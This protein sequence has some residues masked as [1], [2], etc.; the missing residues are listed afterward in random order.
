MAR[1]V[2]CFII[3]VPKKN[4]NAYKKMAKISAK[5]WKKAGA[6]EYIETFADDVAKGKITSFPRSVKLKAGEKLVLG[7]AFY[8][9]RAHRDKVMAKVHKDENLMKQWEQ[10]PFDGMRMIWGGFKSFVSV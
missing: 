4:L 5:A 9:S 7:Y 8:K 3:P 1:Y 6:V 2:D 10:M